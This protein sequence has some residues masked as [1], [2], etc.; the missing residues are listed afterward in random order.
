M[1]N[2][3][4]EHNPAHTI[5]VQ[6]SADQL[7]PI[8]LGL[9]DL[10]KE[11]NHVRATRS[12]RRYPDLTD[13]Y[14][15]FNCHQAPTDE[16]MSA[17]I[18]AHAK[19]QA[20][21]DTGGWLR[22]D[23]RELAVC[24]LAVS[25]AKRLVRKKHAQPW[26]W[27]YK[28]RAKRLHAFIE[29]YRKRAMKSLPVCDREPQREQIVND[30]RNVRQRLAPSVV[31]RKRHPFERRH[32][33]ELIERATRL[34]VVGL[35]MRGYEAPTDVRPLTPL[36]RARLRNYARKSSR[37]TKAEDR[38][39]E[40]TRADGAAARS[41]FLSNEISA[42]LTL[43]D[44]IIQNSENLVTSKNAAERPRAQQA[45]RLGANT[46][47]P[48]LTTAEPNPAP[49]PK[50]ELPAAVR[51]ACGELEWLM[52]E[53]FDGKSA[54]SRMSRA[55]RVD[56]VAKAKKQ[57]GPGLSNRHIARIVGVDDKTIARMLD[58]AA[59]PAQVRDQVARGKKSASQALREA[60]DP[61]YQQSKRLLRE[62]R[63]GS[64]SSEHAHQLTSFL[65]AV[66]AP[67]ARQ[68]VGRAKELVS[69]LAKPERLHRVVPRSDVKEL[70]AK[71]LERLVQADPDDPGIEAPAQR[72]CWW[73]LQVAPEREIHIR[74]L[75]KAMQALRR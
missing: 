14:G 27:D 42:A 73:L 54:W 44:Y 12:L 35:G 20:R 5:R 66:S 24:A 16:Q 57:G 25:H 68:I 47:P 19:V 2:T 43:A 10:V 65:R 3:H 56:A 21:V 37:E 9:D 34:A 46:T 41:R 38:N 69:R 1:S 26:A 71:S 61:V 67:F 60:D 50:K 22:L 18:S 29:Q 11:N 74:A 39:N 70:M 23:H 32:A 49:T 31:E 17:V 62:R 13:E 36:V 33:R 55:A 64:V 59:L 6:F 15:R 30:L 40:E 58:E 8:F 7:K 48:A 52:T 72:L 4:E 51:I 45:Q 75:D 28:K 53:D 63:D